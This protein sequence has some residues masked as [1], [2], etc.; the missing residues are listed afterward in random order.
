MRRPVGSKYLLRKQ[1][2]K[3]IDEY[4]PR[5]STP[6]EAELLQ[7]ELNRMRQGGICNDAQYVAYMHQ[8]K[9]VYRA[10]NWVYSE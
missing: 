5:I 1:V 3:V 8:I 4:I 7:S 10:H 2:L 6:A 9:E